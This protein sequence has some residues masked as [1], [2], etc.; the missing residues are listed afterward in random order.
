MDLFEDIVR[1]TFLINENVSINSV[2]D[3]IN[4]LHPV[5]IAYDDEQGGNGKNKRLIYPVAYG[6]TSKGNPVI[7]AFQPQGSSKRGLT[8]PPNDRE[9]PMWKFFR[10]DRIKFWR[11]IS[12]KTF[13][14]KSLD[15]FNESGDKTMSIVYTIAPI[16]NA[17][18]LAKKDNTIGYKPITKQDVENISI[19]TENEPQDNTD[20][21]A[22]VEQP[23]KRYSAKEIIN[24][25]LN[26]IKNPFNRKNNVDI[27]QKKQDNN[28]NLTTNDTEPITKQEVEPVNQAQSV[29]NNGNKNNNAL[30]KTTTDTPVTK[31]DVN[32]EEQEETAVNNPITNGYKDMVS[33]WNNLEK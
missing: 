15:G 1:D 27:S 13:D 9:Y 8:T 21:K 32:Q 17:K 18:K 12:S 31:N 29:V 2:N 26:K 3:A 10:I 24:N 11:V 22:S 30:S 7:R 19:E 23:R 28:K 5:W 25:I 14:G 20:N 6:L 16:G 33:R 4:G